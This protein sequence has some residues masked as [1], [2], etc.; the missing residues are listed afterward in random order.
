MGREFWW[1]GSDLSDATA[2]SKLD[3]LPPESALFSTNYFYLW[4]HDGYSG[5]V[6]K[7]KRCK[8]MWQPL[9][10]LVPLYIALCESRGLADRP[11]MKDILVN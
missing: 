6:D 8:W 3:I 1:R 11:V 2:G 10:G 4:L 9:R 7:R 5:S